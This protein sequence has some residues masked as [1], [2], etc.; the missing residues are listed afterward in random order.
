VGNYE[1]EKF[2][3]LTSVGWF[4]LFTRT[5]YPSFNTSNVLVGSSASIVSSFALSILALFPQI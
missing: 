1:Q 4:F 5:S 3:V 2:L